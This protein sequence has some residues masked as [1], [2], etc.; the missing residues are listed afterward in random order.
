MKTNIQAETLVIQVGLRDHGYSPIPEAVEAMF[1]NDRAGNRSDGGRIRTVLV[2]PQRHC[3][4]ATGFTEPPIVVEEIGSP[5]K[6]AA[7]LR[8]RAL[9]E[10]GQCLFSGHRMGDGSCFRTVGQVLRAACRM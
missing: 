6:I 10:A 5:D 8:K 1:K 4:L 3:G 2:A 9:P 7:A